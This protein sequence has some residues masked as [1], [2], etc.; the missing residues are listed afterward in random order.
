[1]LFEV[2]CVIW[3]PTT[4]WRGGVFGVLALHMRLRL[5][6]LEGVSCVHVLSHKTK[7]C[8]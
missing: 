4:K 8:R 1:M 2:M 7:Q 5:G 6:G 3:F